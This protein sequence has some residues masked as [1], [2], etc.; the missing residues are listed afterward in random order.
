MIEREKAK[1]L[2]GTKR[3][4]R[5]Q[6]SDHFL[7]LLL[8]Q[9]VDH[10]STFLYRDMIGSEPD[11]MRPFSRVSI[12]FATQSQVCALYARRCNMRWYPC[13]FDRAGLNMRFLLA[14]FSWFGSLHLQF[15]ACKSW[16]LWVAASLPS[17]W[18]MVVRLL[19]NMAFSLWLAIFMFVSAA[20]S[21][22]ISSPDLMLPQ[23]GSS[24]NLSFLS[25]INAS[26]IQHATKAVKPLPF[27]LGGSATSSRRRLYSHNV[28]L[29]SSESV[30]MECYNRLLALEASSCRQAWRDIPDWDYT[31]F[32]FGQRTF[33]SAWDVPLPCRFTSCERISVQERRT[34][35]LIDSLA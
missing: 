21:L 16:F 22:E 5:G 26:A 13:L 4:C 34:Y 14:Q 7:M 8:F 6:R 3:E 29:T 10:Y 33:N 20:F 27:L 12:G 18:K 11:S 23:T 24:S 2:R 32:T 9:E 15:I 17:L 1:T 31:V 30:Q 35:E 25:S 28:N 19:Y